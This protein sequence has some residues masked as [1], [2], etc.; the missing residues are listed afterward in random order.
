MSL[1]EIAKNIVKLRWDKDFKQALE[2]Y[3]SQI[4][5]HFSAHEIT[6]QE[7]MLGAVIDCLK[8]TRKIPEAIK[9]IEE[10]W[11]LQIEKINDAAL[12]RNISWA[13]CF[14]LA[15]DAE[16]KLPLCQLRTEKVRKLLNE[17]LKLKE[18]NL[19]GLLFFRYC[20]YLS[21][22]QP[23]LWVDVEIL[24]NA[25]N[26]S[27]FSDEIKTIS[28]QVK[29]TEKDA[30]LASNREKWLVF[31]TKALFALER[32]DNC[33]VA[34][35]EALEQLK[36]FHHG[37]Q[38]WIIRRM[39]L[40]YKQKG[41]YNRAIHELEKLLQKRQEWF[42]QKELA[43]LYFQKQLYEKALAMCIDACVNQGYS[44]YKT[45]LFQLGG[46]IYFA[47]EKNHN[48]CTMYWLA[49]VTRQEQSWKIPEVLQKAVQQC[50]QMPKEGARE[51]YENLIHHW[52][53]TRANGKPISTGLPDLLHG[54][55]SITRILHNGSNGDGFIT[56]ESGIGIYFRF[57]TCR[58]K[59]STIS[60]GQLVTYTA[61]QIERNGKKVYNALQV[62][63][64]TDNK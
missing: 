31:K 53:N 41:E 8:E 28:I 11:Q 51:L 6:G 48:A 47:M 26:S 24:L 43:E 29:G 34:C 25:F 23:A 13:Y 33:I 42:T 10:F 5:G 62:F 58:I 22:P 27:D 61:R 17:L 52:E 1:Y 57:N 4:H 16:R 60:E 3:R 45:A 38:H 12:V 2:I 54:K 35:Q 46:D 32:Y 63:P 36:R 14:A 40:C 50:G 64:V 7:K 20:D 19:F 21:R 44:E 18:T 55:G 56:G 49:F 39:S 59:P 30:E 37:N 9:M 15:I